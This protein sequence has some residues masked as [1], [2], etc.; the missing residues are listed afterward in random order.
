[1]VRPFFKNTPP[2]AEVV[3]E[4]GP[5]RR[6]DPR[7]YFHDGETPFAEQSSGVPALVKVPLLCFASTIGRAVI[8][9]LSLGGVGFLAPSRLEIPD[10][11]YLKM[12]DSP[13][14]QCRILHRR[15]VAP[16]LTFYGACWYPNNR[17][18][19]EGIMAQWFKI[20]QQEDED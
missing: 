16:L 10:R 20:H 17:R 2:L 11:V 1:M 14:L 12:N 8:K 19:M 18:E 6:L 4:S 5:G 15:E 13:T 3:E 7:V 9:D